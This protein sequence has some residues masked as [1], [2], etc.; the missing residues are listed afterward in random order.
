MDV[1]DVAKL[2]TK[3]VTGDLVHL[4]LALLYCVGAQADEDGVVPPLSAI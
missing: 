3:I 1:D 4:D 2:D